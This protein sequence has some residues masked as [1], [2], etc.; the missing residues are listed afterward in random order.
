MH[1]HMHARTCVLAR[2]CMHKYN[3]AQHNHIAPR[4]T[5]FF[6]AYATNLGAPNS[7]RTQL[8]NQP[9]RKP[10][11]NGS[12]GHT[13]IANGIGS[14]GDGD[15]DMPT[16]AQTSS[17][18]LMTSPGRSRSDESDLGHRKTPGGGVLVPPLQRTSSHRKPPGL[19]DD[20]V[21][22][23]TS[24]PVIGGRGDV[25]TTAQAAPSWGAYPHERTEPSYER[26]VTPAGGSGPS[27]YVALPPSTIC[28]HRICSTPFNH[29]ILCS[30]FL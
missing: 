30:I 14:W 18:F 6:A 8:T 26:I 23:Y 4:T 21:P 24:L 11:K 19:F 5:T 15:D 27:S 20:G 7:S 12:G 2:A 10:C 9:R 22:Q 16:L 3:T 28:E 25:G 13:D 29:V 17:N 1:G